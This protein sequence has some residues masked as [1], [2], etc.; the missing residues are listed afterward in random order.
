[1]IAGKRI[2]LN[3]RVL[4]GI[5]LEG[6]WWYSSCKPRLWLW[7]E[8]RLQKK[9]MRNGEC[10]M[11]NETKEEIRVHPNPYSAFRISHSAF[12]CSVISPHILHLSFILHRGSVLDENKVT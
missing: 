8:E 7:N 2:M 5:G 11:G 3:D 12:V 9:R 6:S 10:G 1:M 4:C